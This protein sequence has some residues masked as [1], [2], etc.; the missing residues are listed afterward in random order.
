[1]WPRRLQWKHEYYKPRQCVTTHPH[2]HRR[3]HR[4]L[5]R[6]SSCN[7]SPDFPVRVVVSECPCE[8][9]PNVPRRHRTRRHPL[10]L[11]RLLSSAPRRPTSEYEHVRQTWCNV[12]YLSSLTF[13]SLGV[14][15]RESLLQTLYGFLLVFPSRW[16]VSQRQPA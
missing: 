10:H 15:R 16:R 13:S 4:H 9:C 6:R 1:M 8:D 7:H 12:A 11:A 2:H 5:R 14:D 3:H